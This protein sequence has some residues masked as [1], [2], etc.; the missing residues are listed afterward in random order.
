MFEKE[1]ETIINTVKL[2]I[3]HSITDTSAIVVKDIMAADIPLALKTFF[4]ADV[5]ILLMEELN[6]TRKNSRF[7]FTHPEV[8]SLQQQMNSFIVLH[9][10]FHKNEFYQ[11]LDD[12]VHLLINYLIRPQWTL[13][14]VIFEQGDSISTSALMRLMKYFGPYEYIRSLILRYI[15][16]RRSTSFTKAEFANILWRVD[17]EFIRRKTGDQLAK[18]LTPLYDFMEYPNNSGMNKIPLKALS[19]YFADMGLTSAV[20]RIEEEAAT[21]VHEISRKDL[22]EVLESIRRASG[23]FEVASRTI[24]IDGAKPPSIEQTSIPEI[25]AEEPEQDAAAYPK[26]QFT[27]EKKE[28]PQTRPD[29]QHPVQSQPVQAEPEIEIPSAPEPVP[30]SPPP[31]EQPA[32]TQNETVPVSSQE[33]THSED[34]QPY[35]IYA[36]NDNDR[37]KFIKKIFKEDDVS[38]LNTLRK[39]DEL[40]T[41]RQASVYIDEIFIQNDIDPYSSEAIRFIDI[42]QEKYYP[43]K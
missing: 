14:N 39:L 24:E 18:I 43:R 2:R 15:E 40:P 3:P 30:T 21:G 42:I 20:K 19:R 23:A 9:Y 4:R 28:E 27:F 22:G 10:A 26:Y 29:I 1:T 16:D 12:A 13:A 6:R 31:V 25:P 17:G 41:W 32:A 7:N 11:R 33:T 5:E 35:L 36:I 38:F 8:Q 37:K 34:K